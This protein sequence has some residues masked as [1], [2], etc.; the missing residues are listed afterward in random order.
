MGDNKSFQY[1]AILSKDMKSPRALELATPFLS[2][3]LG[4][5]E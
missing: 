5:I 4:V 3:G 1:L 2:R